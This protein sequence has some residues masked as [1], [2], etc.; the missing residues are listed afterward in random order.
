MT[1]EQTH[2][3]SN[4]ASTTSQLGTLSKLSS[5]F[6]ICKKGTEELL[7]WLKEGLEISLALERCSVSVNDYHLPCL[8]RVLETLSTEGCAQLWESLSIKQEM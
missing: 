6:L 1:E 8:H 2:L 4:P 3:A 5:A 7:V